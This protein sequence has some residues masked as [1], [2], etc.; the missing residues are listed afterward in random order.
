MLITK[1]RTVKFLWSL[2]FF[3]DFMHEQGLS[4]DSGESF[5]PRFCQNTEF[6]LNHC[7]RAS[8]LQP[9]VVRNEVKYA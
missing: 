9:D 6:P 2:R 4:I 3:Y 7:L 8:A 1:M 5:Q